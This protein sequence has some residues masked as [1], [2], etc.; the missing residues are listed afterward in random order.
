MYIRKVIV[1]HDKNYD[2]MHRLLEKLKE[3]DV[4]SGKRLS[5]NF[6]PSGT[7][8]RYNLATE[9]AST[10]IRRDVANLK[11]SQNLNSFFIHIYKL[12]D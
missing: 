12:F 2:G 7:K 11:H 10:N 1:Y 3:K 4:D 8:K 9:Q 6:F 5:T